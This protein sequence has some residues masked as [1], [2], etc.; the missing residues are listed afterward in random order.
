M[1]INPNFGK[2]HNDLGVEYGRKGLYDEAIKEFNVAIAKMPNPAQA[3]HNLGL[4]YQKKGEP[5]KAFQ[6]FQNA[7]KHKQT[8]TTDEHR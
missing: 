1:A 6:A 4:A 8:E 5:E 3:Y 2:A 7:M